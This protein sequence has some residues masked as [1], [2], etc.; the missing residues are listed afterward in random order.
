MYVPREVLMKRLWE[1]LVLWC[2][3][4]KLDVRANKSKHTSEAG[5]KFD[6]K[7]TFD[8]DEFRFGCWL[9]EDKRTRIEA[10]SRQRIED[11]A[12]ATLKIHGGVLTPN[13]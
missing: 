1:A 2:E 13:V 3:P 5:R 8:L 9:S 12:K 7:L 4:S 6:L 10:L 11:E